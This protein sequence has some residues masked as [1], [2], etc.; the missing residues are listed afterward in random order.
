MAVVNIATEDVTEG[1]WGYRNGNRGSWSLVLLVL[2]SLPLLL[3]GL[4]TQG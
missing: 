2:V 4:A 1:K 3:V